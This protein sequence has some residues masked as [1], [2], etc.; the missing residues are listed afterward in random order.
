MVQ[1]H[2][3]TITIN[4]HTCL[5]FWADYYIN[6]YIY[7]N[8]GIIII[9]LD[10]EFFLHS[11]ALSSF[12]SEISKVGA[13]NLSFLF[14]SFWSGILLYYIIRRS[15]PKIGEFCLALACRMSHARLNSHFQ[16]SQGPYI[17]MNFFGKFAE[18]FLI[19]QR[20]ITKIKF[21]IK[22]C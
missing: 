21:E 6:N 14:F 8:F 13:N 4:K 1:H 7:I 9:W 17:K 11:L 15:I 2:F 10:W 22:V 20:T 5:L 16:K 3:L 18:S 19:Y 12:I